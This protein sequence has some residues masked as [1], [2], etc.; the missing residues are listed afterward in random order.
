MRG[1]DYELIANVITNTNIDDDCYTAIV[2]EFCR[3]LPYTSDFF[4]RTIF[5][6]QCHATPETRDEIYSRLGITPPPLEIVA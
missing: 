6:R 4:D 5:L 1:T 2:T 3:A